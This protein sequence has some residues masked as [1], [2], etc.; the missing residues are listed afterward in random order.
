MT[1]NRYGAMAK[2]HWQEWMPSRY[3]RLENPDR[4]FEQLGEQAQTELEALVTATLATEPADLPERE[5]DGWRAMARLNAEDQIIR[6]LIL[7]PPDAA[8]PVEDA[9][10]T[11]SESG[12]QEI[13][14]AMIE[15]EE[16]AGLTEP[17]E[18]P[19]D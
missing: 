11:V 12:Q 2:S 10:P 7:I 17:F 6:E 3:R 18:S 14:R 4:F 9:H 15:A 5:R 8:S 19:T 1:M 13:L 16:R